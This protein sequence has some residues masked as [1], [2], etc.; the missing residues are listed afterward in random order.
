MPKPRWGWFAVSVVAMITGIWLVSAGFATSTQGSGPP[1]G[2][3]VAVTGLVAVWA[4][5][6]AFFNFVIPRRNKN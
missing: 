1:G 3:L 4:F 6:K 5:G 2:L